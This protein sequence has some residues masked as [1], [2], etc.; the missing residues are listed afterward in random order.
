ML[1]NYKISLY[2]FLEI[3]KNFQKI[4]LEKQLYTD[5]SK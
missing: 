1:Q 2:K 5:K 4:L 3:S